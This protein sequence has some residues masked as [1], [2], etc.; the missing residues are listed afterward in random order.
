LTDCEEKP[1][2]RRETPK[3]ENKIDAEFVF[4]QKEKYMGEQREQI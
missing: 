3:G 1:R 2:E 4:V